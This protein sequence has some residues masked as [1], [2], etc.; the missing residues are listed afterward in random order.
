MVCF[1]IGEFKV[2]VWLLFLHYACIHE[3]FGKNGSKCV[4]VKQI[5]K[6]RI[7]KQNYFCFYLHM[8]PI[9]LLETYLKSNRHLVVLGYYVTIF[10]THV[11]ET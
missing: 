1:E 3:L 4:I 9:A 8:M 6:E 7:A 5:I 10:R 2:H 11:K